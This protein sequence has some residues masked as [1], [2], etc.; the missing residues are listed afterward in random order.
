[1][2]QK[3]I[4]YGQLWGA[5]ITLVVGILFVVFP[6]SIVRW[7]VKIIGIVSLVG[8][9]AQIISYF[10]YRNNSPRNSFPIFGILILLWG[11][12][13]LAQPALWVN[14]FMIVMSVPMI[15]LAVMQL[16]AIS[17][18]RRMGFEI[19]WANYVFP[20]LFLLAGVVVVF[21]PFSTAMW[22]V[23]FVGLW[24]IVYGVVGLVNFFRFGVGR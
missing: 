20:I 5:V 6:E 15:L 1:M 10:A 13:L 11:I 22:L 9:A 2:E 17:R 16:M 24:C 4:M 8:G 19:S 23:L 21:N 7:I 14:L 3:K 18:Q 12:L